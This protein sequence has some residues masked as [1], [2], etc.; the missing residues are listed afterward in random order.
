MGYA[1]IGEGVVM[2]LKVG[3]VLL[4]VLPILACGAGIALGWWL[5]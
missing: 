3:A 1:K 4:V 5:Q 2:L